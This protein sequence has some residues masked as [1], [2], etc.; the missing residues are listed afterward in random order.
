MKRLPWNTFAI[1]RFFAAF[2]ISHGVL[3]VQAAPANG[4]INYVY[5]ELGRLVGVSDATGNSAAYKYD[6]VGNIL[7]ISRATAAQVSLSEFTPN[8]GPVGTT[9]TIFGSGFSITAIQNTVTFNLT[10]ATVISATSTKI[11][12]SVPAGATTGTIKITTPTGS[13]TS[14]SV[15]TVGPSLVPT[16]ASFTPTVGSAG[17][18]VTISGSNYQTT[19]SNN[20]VEFNNR[21][22]AASS[23]TATSIVAPVP[24]S[25]TSGKIAVLTPFGKATSSADFFIPPSP[26]TAAD[27]Q[28]TDRMTIGQSKTVTITTAGKKGLILF[29]GIAGQRVGMV[30]SAVSIGSGIVSILKPDGTVLGSTGVGVDPI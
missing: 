13:V 26:Y 16:I 15:F 24:A 10:A 29:D 28:V 25:T 2:I 27:I 19:L 1:I 7:T 14:A 11:V 6:A 8:G 23:A 21:V 4:P 5:D 3:F 22:T 20:K 30:L 9:V 17:T 18:A 12:A